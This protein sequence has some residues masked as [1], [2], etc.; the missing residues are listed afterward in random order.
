MY[1]RK[2][3]QTPFAEV[4]HF[5]KRDIEFWQA[6]PSHSLTNEQ[7]WHDFSYAGPSHYS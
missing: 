1:T 7:T 3:G 6:G 2:V 4:T 5:S